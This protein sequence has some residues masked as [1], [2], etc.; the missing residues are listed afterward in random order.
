MSRKEIVYWDSDCFLGYFKQE[1]DKIRACRGTAEK[2]KQGDLIITTS[3]ITLVE[4][5][6]LQKHEVRLSAK[7]EKTIK[8]FF[9]NPYI[10]IH[11]VDREVATHARQLIWKNNLSQ[12]D[13]IHV[14]TA[15]LRKIPTMHTF[16]K[17]LLKLDD[18]FGNPRLHI[19]RPGAGDQ[20][21][22]RDL[23][24]AEGT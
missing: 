14:A 5:V 1:E 17:D 15:V 6:R 13:S 12:R 18:H 16:D 2:A 4:V 7:E 10:Y 21:D 9:A 20:M 23:H 8:D 3:A 22:F 24:D 11:N 19:C